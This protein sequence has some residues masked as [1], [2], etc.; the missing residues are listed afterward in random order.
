M[1]KTYDV[2]VIGAGIIGMATGYYL[3]DTGMKIAVIDK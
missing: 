3:S 2:A 1:N